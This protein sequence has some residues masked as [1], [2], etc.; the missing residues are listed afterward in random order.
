M[1]THGLG[2]ADT[3]AALD[4]AVDAAL[5]RVRTPDLG[6]DATTDDVVEAVLA[7]L[8]FSAAVD[9]AQP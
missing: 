8:E 1:L 2:E 7:A 9:S 5:E 4:A 6:G 3:G